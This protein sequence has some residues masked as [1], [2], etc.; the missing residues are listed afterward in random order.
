MTA[1]PGTWTSE[2]N[3]EFKSREGHE[4]QFTERNYGAAPLNTA[5]AAMAPAAAAGAQ[6]IAVGFETNE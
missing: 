6:K 1:T 3:E 2:M 5:A 4:V